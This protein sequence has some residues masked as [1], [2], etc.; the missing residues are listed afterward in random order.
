MLPT[1]MLGGVPGE[2][3]VGV[4]GDDVADGAEQRPVA[5][6]VGEGLGAPGRPGAVGGASRRAGLRLAR[7]PPAGGR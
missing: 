7:G 5:D 4:Q 1:S 3:G 2:L 6:D